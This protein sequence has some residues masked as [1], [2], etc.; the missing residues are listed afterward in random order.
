M[1]LIR[2][3][4]TQKAALCAQLVITVLKRTLLQSQR[5]LSVMP[6][7]YAHQEHSDRN[8]LTW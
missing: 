4:R 2:D 3:L 7:T 1:E 5:V 6:D 8:P